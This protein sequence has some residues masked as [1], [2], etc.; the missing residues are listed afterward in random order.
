MQR[1]F[2]LYFLITLIGLIFIGRLFHLQ[3]INGDSYDPIHNNAA[4]KIEYD[5]P[6]R[7]YIYDRNGKLLVANQLSYDVMVQPNQ[8]KPLDT[9]EFCKL[10]KIDKND[11]IARFE[12]AYNYAP[13]LP[14][15]FL[16]QLAKEDFAFLQ[17]KLHKYQGF[18]IQKRIIR[19]YPIK[20]AANVLGYIGEVNEEKARNSTYYQQGELEGKDGVE[21]QYEDVLRGKKGK[22]YLHRNRFNK[23]TGSYKNGINDTLPVNGKDIT[24]TLDIDL[25]LYAQKLMNGKRG[26]I[27]AIEP[28]SGEILALVTAP[29]YDPNM[30][31]G[32]K[33]S[34]NSVTLFNDTISRPSYDRGLLAAYPPGS[35]FK[36]M[37]AL[38][39]LQEN[40]I[41]SNTSFTCYG[42][43]RYGNR[44][45]EFMKCHC[46][47]YGRPIQLRTA[48]AKS[49]NSYFSNTYKRIVE[50][51]NNPSE[52]LNNWNK[53]VTSFGLGNYLGY[54]LPAGA[55]GLVPDG[56]YYDRR[57]KYRWNGSSN[58]SNAIGQGEILTTPIQLAN[59]TAAIANRGYFY[60][61]HIVKKIDKKP[62]RDPKYTE[63]K[64]TTI[65]KK[66][67]T[68]V[69]DAM[70]EVFKTGTGRWSQ[71]DGIAICGKTGTAE[72]FIRVDGKKIQLEDHSI[73]VAFAPKDNPKI[74]LA[75]FVE[76]GGYGSTIAAPITS[77][78]VEKYLNGDISAKNKYREQ[79]MLT[80]SL[81]NIYD[82]QI[83]NPEEFA[84]GTK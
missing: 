70:Y 14:S 5:Y 71:V 13:F 28:S 73:L 20:A 29:T 37:N 79:N 61:P 48:I 75:V 55:P 59:F 19:D 33:R 17:E 46:D 72:N 9:L 39:G 1:G 10:L 34:K 68:P 42:G 23:V 11:F 80:L 41:N 56:N 44:T 76:N 49:C 18:Y 36:M 16:K 57:L 52:G 32:R 77:L 50:K 81:Q 12:K 78:L 51:D 38:I 22:K 6:E 24:L 3:V 26:G 15:V 4:V 60:T 43:F 30:L 40:V 62:I 66:H 64:Q 65:D 84:S 54:D 35:P 69:I 74:A 27:V 83:E 82:L 47:I 25:Q 2:L 8:V 67:F 21:R 63:A 53:H 58:I 31:V 7:G 45:N